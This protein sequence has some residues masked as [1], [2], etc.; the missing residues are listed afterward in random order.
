MLNETKYLTRPNVKDQM[1]ANLTSCL[2]MLDPLKD[3][4]SMGHTDLIEVLGF[5][6]YTLILQAKN[7]AELIQKHKEAMSEFPDEPTGVEGFQE[8]V[9][10]RASQGLSGILGSVNLGEIKVE[11]IDLDLND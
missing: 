8:Y 2:N 5:M 9:A 11:K 10:H 6:R 1:L 4:G 7:V 3:F